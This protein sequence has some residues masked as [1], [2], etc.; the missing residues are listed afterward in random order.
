MSDP[1]LRLDDAAAA[2]VHAGDD[3]L[4]PH[5][6]GTADDR[7]IA[8]A[9]VVVFDSLEAAGPL[10]DIL[11][12]KAP[13][14][15]YQTRA[16]LR[17]WLETEG[18]AHGVRPFIVAAL[19]GRGRPVAILPLGLWAGAAVRGARFLG[20][21][22]ANYNMGLFDPAVVWSDADLRA[23]LGHAA[24]KAP[25][26]VD[27]FAF[28]NQPI[29]WRDRP[30]P[31]ARLRGQPS[32]SLGHR[33]VLQRDGDAFLRDHLSAAARKKMRS[34]RAQLD[35]LGPVSHRI[36]RSAG[37]IEATLAAHLAQKAA[38]LEALGVDTGKALAAQG[39]LLAR[40]AH[41][42]GGAMAPLELHALCCGARIVATFG[43]LAHAGR[44][45]GLLISYENDPAYAR[46]SPGELLLA[47]VVRL[48]CA[49]GLDSFDLGIGEARYKQGFCP[50]DDPLVDSFVPVTARGRLFVAQD[51][52]RLRL[53]GTIKRSAWAWAVARRTR[54]WLGRLRR[55]L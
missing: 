26:R 19:D 13:V 45:S 4:V 41:D 28:V 14:S 5:R 8:F 22:H 18:L 51:A 42:P 15:P 38:K 2:S 43:G 9:E 32:P 20:G 44:F 34:K 12:D 31:L 21:V 35:A 29:D 23:L 25:A 17:A 40:A 53:K 7:R 11:E 48:K 6:A 30:N 46:L 27:V 37:E 55:A 50:I 47:D 1:A 54:R 24:R 36:A 10:W 52:L 3:A 33:A 16:W 49:E 39:R